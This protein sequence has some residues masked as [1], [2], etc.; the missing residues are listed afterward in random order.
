MPKFQ[1]PLG[2][3]SPH[4]QTL[5]ARVPTRASQRHGTGV[6]SEDVIL[7]CRDGVRLEARVTPGRT[8]APLVIIL[9]GWLGDS[10]SWY[11]ERTANVLHAQGY[12]IASLLLRDHGGTASHNR[13]MFNSAR[14][15]EVVDAC[16]ALAEGCAA[17]VIGFSL[18]GNFALRL[19]GD[20]QTDSGFKA[21]L[22]VSPVI[23]PARTVRAIDAGWVIYRK[24]FVTKWHGA[25][26]EKQ[27]AFPDDYA[28][29]DAALRL[30]TVAGITDFLIGRYLPYRDSADYYA[31]Y[32]LRG[33]ALARVR[34]DTR[35]VAARDDMMIPADSYNDVTHN[36]R[37]DLQMFD[38]GGHCGFVEDWRLNAYLDEVVVEYFRA[39]LTAA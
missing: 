2:L 24:W 13:E 19:A 18:G 9:H 7:N 5:L 3:T 30:S 32:D 12:R 6:C 33:E 28:E 38:H 16:N 37:V 20:P 26:E 34:I 22:A 25:L 1:P 10:R 15:G 39:R 14:L 17:G 4:L 35:I 23:D 8:G 21:C 11:V 31:R 36:D 27:A 29:L